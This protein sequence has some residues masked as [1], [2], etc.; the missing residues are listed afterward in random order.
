MLKVNYR[1]VL[2]YLLTIISNVYGG[3]EICIT[4]K[5]IDQYSKE[6]LPNANIK[7]VNTYSGTACNSE[8][9]F[10]MTLDSARY[11]I[12]I[13]YLGYQ[14]KVVEINRSSYNMVIELLPTAVEINTVEVFAYNW[15]ER[16]MLDAI[17]VKNELNDS[18]H[19]FTAYTYSKTSFK[20]PAPR[21]EIFGMWESVS[22]ISFVYP[23]KYQE[24]LLNLHTPPQFKN[25]PYKFVSINPKINFHYDEVEIYNLSILSPLADNALDYYYRGCSFYHNWHNTTKNIWAYSYS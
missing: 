10:E 9:Y 20:F 7:I 6:A 5:V 23:D 13:S 22:K 11:K 4:G 21:N 3:S 14:S 16:F 12:K 1:L 18:L 2:F 15:I 25:F 24:H 19:N 17:K 8:G